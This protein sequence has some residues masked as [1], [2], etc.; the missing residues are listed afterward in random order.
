MDF[1]SFVI[2]ELDIEVG[3]LLFLNW[4][5]HRVCYNSLVPLRRWPLRNSG[6]YYIAVLSHMKNQK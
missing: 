3:A 5:R 1:I 6:E 4:G 2:K